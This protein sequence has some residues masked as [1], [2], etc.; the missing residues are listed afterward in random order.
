MRWLD[1]IN[2]DEFEQAL[3]DSEGQ[4]SLAWLQSMGSQR[5]GHNLAIKQEQNVKKKKTEIPSLKN[6]LLLAN[7]NHHLT[8][9]GRHKSSSYTKK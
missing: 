6:T 5:V 1:G 7:V 3:G 9:Q 4:G 8:R 2:G